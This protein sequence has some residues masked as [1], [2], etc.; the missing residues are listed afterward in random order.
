MCAVRRASI[1]FARR[2]EPGTATYDL[3]HATFRR[4]LSTSTPDHDHIQSCHDITHSFCTANLA[5]KLPCRVRRS[6]IQ[7][8]SKDIWSRVIMP[9]IKFLHISASS[10][11]CSH[12]D[13]SV[14][15]C[16]FI[17]IHIWYTPVTQC[18]Y[19]AHVKSAMNGRA[20]ASKSKGGCILSCRRLLY[21]CLLTMIAQAVFNPLSS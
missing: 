1:A 2:L 11:V 13:L 14:Q 5:N 21:T 19:S 15:L 7:L 18:A 3:F 8:P 10:S 6:H 12:A 4:H 17:I 20:C 16:C 9:P